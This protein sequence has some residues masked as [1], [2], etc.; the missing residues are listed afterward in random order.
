[1]S[2]TEPAAMPDEKL[3]E[4]LYKLSGLK[5]TDRL[6]VLPV[7]QVALAAY[8]AGRETAKASKSLSAPIK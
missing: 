1:M 4:F 7:L 6:Q 2:Q 5:P 3:A 8:N